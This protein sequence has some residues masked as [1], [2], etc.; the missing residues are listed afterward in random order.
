MKRFLKIFA[1]VLALLFAIVLIIPSLLSGKISDIVKREANNMLNAK[2]EFSE[3]DISLLRHFPKA[4]LELVDF[5]VTG[6]GNLR[7][8]PL[9]RASALR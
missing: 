2:V 3:L 5:S 8:R 9:L 4:S 1:I 6:V 7:V